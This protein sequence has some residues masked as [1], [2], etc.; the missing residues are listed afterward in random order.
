LRSAGPGGGSSAGIPRFFPLDSGV[1]P[2]R[3]RTVL[4][5]G[6]A[7]AGLAAAAAAGPQDPVPPIPF[8]PAVTSGVLASGLRYFIRPNDRPAGRA[9]LR[10]VVDAG[11]LL[12]DDD[13]RG[14]AHF[15]EHMA[16]DGTAHFP[17]RALAGF[18]ES[19][20]MAFGPEISAS[21]SFE[22]TVYRLDVPSDSLPALEAAFGLL[23]DW[24][25]GID[26]DP[27]EIA[28]E[29]IA[30]L[31]ETRTGRG[32]DARLLDRRLPALLDG[33]R[34]PERLPVG[35]RDILESFD[36]GTLERFY[37]D[38]Y[39]PDRMAVVAVG[40]FDV[41]L[42][43]SLI[44]SRFESLAPRAPART[45][46]SGGARARDGVRVRVT[47]DPGA[48]GS[49]IGLY[50]MGPVR[51][52]RTVADY[53]I[54]ILEN[55]HD[56]MMNRRLAERAGR[57][58]APFR[59]GVAGKGR[60]TRSR[61]VY[62]LGA[63][64]GDG[65]VERGIEA[66]LAEAERVR[67]YGFLPSEFDRARAGLL[68]DLRLRADGKSKSESSVFANA[69]VRSWLNG[70][71]DPAA[72]W[73]LA[74]ATG[75][76]P[77]V[78]LDEINRLT[79]GWTPDSD[80]VI[81][82]DVPARAGATP[83]RES[84]LRA[85]FTR[86]RTAPVEPAVNEDPSAPPAEA[87]PTAGRIRSE[88]RIERIGVTEWTLSNGVAV[89]LKPTDFKNDEILFSAFSPGG[90]S[91]STDRN[92]VAAAT[93]AAI[94]QES[95]AA[96]FDRSRKDG[97]PDGRAASVIPVIGMCTEGLSGSG[98]TRDAATLFRRIHLA[99]AAPRRDTAAFGRVRR[100]LAARMQNRCLTPEDAFQD[101]LQVTL[102]GRHPR[103][104]VWTPAV[105]EEMNLDSSLS[106]YRDRF[107]DA[108]DFT[109]LFVGAFSPD[110]LRPLVE[111][112]LGSLPAKGRVETW[113]DPGIRPPKGAVDLTVRRGAGPKARVAIV[114]T[115]SWDGGPEAGY[116][117]ET[118][119]GLLRISLR[120]ALRVAAG[121][122]EDVSVTAAA[123]KFP[124]PR[125]TLN[126]TFAC[127]PGRAGDLTAEALRRIDR[128]TREGSDPG[129][130]SRVREIQRRDLES[131]LRRNAY[132]LDRLS[133]SYFKGED[134]EAVLDRGAWISGLSASAVRETAARVCGAGNVVRAVLLPD[135]A[136]RTGEGSR[137]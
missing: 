17:K 105:L 106:F 34:Y 91:L 126:V 86:V 70:E 26:F 35:R 48:S 117:L 104:R 53:R 23:R 115:A 24:A 137:P 51:I 119:A 131:D 56:A 39:R 129:V 135:A 120:E 25:D 127:E 75:L 102:A 41:R 62:Y 66:L 100:R 82:A 109:F 132:W 36:A 2:F 32:G 130:L 5:A 18:L 68:R 20:G 94:V 76:L 116:R 101:T 58:D 64:V 128:L 96:L 49:E 125:V 123:V 67:R 8:D 16:F 33:T 92:A 136:A 54:S 81:L 93:A 103:A 112:W 71:T 46:P 31:E 59:T 52:D 60:L 69:L 122:A 110:S 114:F 9:E 27:G 40:D 98:S 1:S 37:R 83:P 113:R 99:F 7:L 84:A 88:K 44:R 50:F 63:G 111:T 10:L 77:A 121:G 80:V 11:S 29:R 85:A 21:C 13:Q 118:T 3:L 65:G 73:E 87:P 19:A 89:I 47:A 90:N 134:P 45:P 4:R 124:D 72:E 6:L 107:S 78:R 22:E 42:A 30:V 57:P 74:A 95:G 133:E 14:L 55:L 97:R 12:E 108:G 15:T 61:G 43:E 28:R 38:W 79:A